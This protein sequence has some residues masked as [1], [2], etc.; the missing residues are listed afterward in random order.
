MKVQP[1][2]FADGLLDKEVRKRRVRDDP[3]CD[4]RRHLGDMS[5]FPTLST[6][7]SPSPT[8]TLLLLWFLTLYSLFTDIFHLQIQD[9]P[10][11]SCDISFVILLNFLFNFNL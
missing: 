5:A 2:G 1:T 9:C 8:P 11:F 4:Y 10:H 3:G 7:P 6:H